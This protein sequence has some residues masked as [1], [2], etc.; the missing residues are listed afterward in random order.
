MRLAPASST[1]ARPEFAEH[2]VEVNLPANRDVAGED[3]L[4]VLE[5]AH[6]GDAVSDVHQR[7]QR[8]GALRVVHLVGVGQG[9]RLDVEHDR[10][11]AALGDDRRAV[12]DA[13]A[14]GG[15]EQHVERVLRRVAVAADDLVV[16]L[17]F[18]EVERNVLFGLPG[19]GLVQFGL[20]HRRQRQAFDDDRVARE[21]GDDPRA[22]EAEGVEQLADHLADGRRFGGCAILDAARRAVGLRRRR[23]ATIHRARDEGQQP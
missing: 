20:A 23:Q 9:E 12:V 13:V 4:A 18:G 7:R 8:V 3:R 19:N 21:G 10:L 2:G 17:D 11:P 14:F 22:L 1:P 6:D 5:E 16:E 15:H